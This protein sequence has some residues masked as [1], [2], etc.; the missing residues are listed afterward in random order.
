MQRQKLRNEQL[1]VRE[2][3]RL[4]LFNLQKM[5]CPC[6][7]CHGHRKLLL[8]TIREHLILNKWDPN[9]RVWRR[10]GARDSFD[11]EWEGNMRTHNQRLHVELDSQV[12]TRRM[13]DNAFMEEP[14]P[15]DVEKIVHDVVTGAFDLGDSVHE[16]CNDGSKEGDGASLPDHGV[17]LAED[18]EGQENIDCFDPTMLEEAIQ[19]L[20]EGSRSTKLAAT[21]LLMKLCTVRRVNN[22]FANELFIILHLHLLPEGNILPRNHYVAKSLTS[23]WVS[24]TQAYT[25]EGKV[26]FFSGVNM[27]MP[28]VARNVMDQDLVM[29][30]R[31]STLSKLFVISR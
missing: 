22:N 15:P 26:V 2:V 10:P 4:T 3:Q 11:K 23:S 5:Q 12:D 31:R 7:E 1:W 24:F 30:T 21:I 14:L 20:Y 28:N 6:I 17:T 16:E 9:F 8:K 18:I 25:L 27:R 13:V 19:E 29:E